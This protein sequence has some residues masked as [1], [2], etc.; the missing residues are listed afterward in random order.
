[1]SRIAARTLLCS[2]PLLLAVHLPAQITVI[3]DKDDSRV[4]GP[5]TAV[6]SP[7]AE[8]RSFME[9]VKKEL[10]SPPEF[11]E[12][13]ALDNPPSW[14]R[15]VHPDSGGVLRYH[16][17]FPRGLVCRVTL[18]NLL[19]DHRYVLTINGN[20]ERPGNDLLPDPVPGNAREKFY[21]FLSVTTDAHG[22]YEGTLAILLRPGIYAV[23]FYVKD[24]D[25]FKIVLY[26]DFFKFTVQ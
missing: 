13:R 3:L 15:T 5:D 6:R 10:A 14:G 11:E 25:D 19:P 24:T 20:P 2:A 23:R 8:E 1:M 12:V 22:H 16:A 21:D 17:S 26:R 9:E 4:I 7:V 18:E